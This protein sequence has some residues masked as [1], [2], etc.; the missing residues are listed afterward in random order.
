MADHDRNYKPETDYQSTFRPINAIQA[1]ACRPALKI[2][3]RVLHTLP[4]N[5]LDLV[6]INQQ[7]YTRHLFHTKTKSFK[8]TGLSQVSD[9]P[10]GNDT[11][12]KLHYPP[13]KLLFNPPSDTLMRTTFNNKQDLDPHENYVTMNQEMLKG[14]KGLHFPQ[15]F[16]EPLHVSFFQG[17]FDGQTI[18]R[19]DFNPEIPIK[20]R[21]STSF[22]KI[23][24]S[25][26]TDSDADFAKD[27]TNR[28]TYTR[29]QTIAR[30]DAHLR[31]DGKKN[32]ETLE[33]ARGKVQDLT[34]YRIDNPGFQ[35]RPVRR[36]ACAPAVDSLQLFQGKRNVIS[37]HQ[38]SFNSGFY[39][40]LLR[41]RTSFKKRGQLETNGGFFDGQTSMKTH[42]QPIPI[43]DSLAQLQEVDKL[44]LT[45]GHAYKAGS[46]VK[47]DQD[48]GERFSNNTTNKSHFQ[49]WNVSPRIRHGDKSERVYQPST[50]QKFTCVSEAMSSFVPIDVKPSPIFKPIDSS[51]HDSTETVNKSAYTDDYVPFQVQAKPKCPCS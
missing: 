4:S 30:E 45:I 20:G 21:P 17:K 3:P 13:R 44:A 50:K 5:K 42:F 49:K 40:N 32:R 23:E 1:L 2:P 27:T 9:T 38:A 16:R 7:D 31:K 11:S 28:C 46:Q 10:L 24:K 19:K 8:P 29:P 35:T 14:W 34:Q 12:Y 6:S 47:N 36:S 25:I 39:K 15:P 41:P 33:P 22:K 37:E 48:H 51:F 43:E 26:V 18:A